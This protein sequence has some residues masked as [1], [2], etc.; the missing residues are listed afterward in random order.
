MQ[1]S[2][3]WEAGAGCNGSASSLM[4]HVPDNKGITAAELLKKGEL[5]LTLGAS[6]AY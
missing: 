1:A 5:L 3:C 6:R 2:G 4:A